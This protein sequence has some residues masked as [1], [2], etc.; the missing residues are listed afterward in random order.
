MAIRPKA[1]AT[2]VFLVAGAGSGRFMRVSAPG[3]KVQIRMLYC[4]P[5]IC[6]H[7]STGPQMPPLGGAVIGLAEIADQARGS[8]KC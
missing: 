3:A 2:G 5:S 4:G 6:Q 1:A 7:V 8:R